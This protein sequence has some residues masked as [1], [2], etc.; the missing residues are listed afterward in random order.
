MGQ[1]EHSNDGDR[2][3]RENR[4]WIK[5][6]I[7]I[8]CLAVLLAL[9]FWT[10]DKVIMGPRVSSLKVKA[11]MVDVQVALG[12]F[13]SEYGTFPLSGPYA[14]KDV[15]LRSEGPLLA[16]LIAE[17]SKVNIRQIQFLDPTPAKKWQPGLTKDA[18][19]WRMVDPWGE[20]YYLV[21]DVNM[22]N[23]IANPEAK[24]G[25]LSATIPETI[26]S[27]VILYSSGPDRDPT[28]WEDNV[29]SWR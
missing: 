1:E 7:A 2:G 14:G 27:S 4:R 20:M 21:L 16:A 19:Q 23:R 18:G 17:D 13:R 26:N 12:H 9:V 15:E 10:A 5:V 29:R 24:P 11:A 6:V 3:S 28:T 8:L 22:D 25:N